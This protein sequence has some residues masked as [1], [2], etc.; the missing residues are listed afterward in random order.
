VATSRIEEYLESIF[1]LQQTEHPVSVSRLAEHLK[2]SAPSVSGMMKKLEQ[3]GL[4]YYAENRG[5]C[6]TE[7]G[8]QIARKVVRRHL[9]SERFLT[10][11]LGL[12]WHEVHDEA[13][14]LE[15]VISPEVE[16]RLAQSLGNPQTCPHGHAIPDKKGKVLEEKARPLAELEPG[17]KAIVLRVSE[18]D[19]KMLQYLATLG[20][21]PEVKVE[22]TEIAPFGGPILI[23]VG[24]AKYALGHGVATKILVKE[25]S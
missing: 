19:P 3:N 14:K 15:H 25:S 4:I 8:E 23:K 21:M 7:K 17:K 12:K 5:V 16:E 20:L 22:V 9:L 11:I 10:D 18:E 2:L 13:C 6:L 1:K 24:R